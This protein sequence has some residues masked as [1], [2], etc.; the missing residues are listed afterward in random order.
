MNKILIIAAHPDDDILGCGG[1]MSKYRNQIEFKVIFIAEGS[2][3]RFDK[4]DIVAENTQKIIKNRNSCGVIALKS[5]GV[6]NYHFYNFPC[7]RLDQVPIIEINKIIENEINKFKPDTV[8]THSSDDTNND[9]IIV[10]RATQMATRPGARTFVEKLYTY[11]ILSS[12]EWR[13]TKTFSPNYFESLSESNVE[14][15][16]SALQKYMSEIKEYPYPR[17]REGVFT[18]AKYRGIQS[19]NRYSEAFRLIREM[20]R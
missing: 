13:F 12:T 3:C 10:H 16:W 15:K 1:L 7:G 9:H 6:K 20:K 19:A 17:S 8:F 14:E 11:E 4:K 5:L 18:L 2:S